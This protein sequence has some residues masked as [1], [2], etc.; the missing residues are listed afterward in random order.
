M[1]AASKKVTMDLSKNK[2]KTTF[3][4]LTLLFTN[5]IFGIVIMISQTLT[6]EI[7][8]EYYN[9]APAEV[10]IKCSGYDKGILSIL[11]EIPEIEEVKGT[12]TLVAQIVVNRKKVN[13]NLSV[14]DD[15]NRVNILKNKDGKSKIPSLQKNEI[16]I[17]RAAKGALGVLAGE[18]L[19]I[20]IENKVS[21]QLVLKDYVY[22]ASAEPY[23]LEG[24]VCGFITMDNYQSLPGDGKYHEI[25]L[26][27]KGDGTKAY[28]EAICN[29]ASDLLSKSGVTV[30][31]TEVVNSDSFYASLALKAINIILYVLGILIIIMSCSLIFNIFN[32]TMLQQ[33]KVIGI[34]K[35]YGGSTAQ[36]SR[37]Y[38]AQMVMI[39]L[40]TYLLSIPISY[41]IAKFVS[42]KLA[43]F[44]NI[45]L[46]KSGMPLFLP[47]VLFVSTLIIP[48]LAVSIPIRKAS[49]ATV[50]DAMNLNGKGGSFKHSGG[51]NRLISRLHTLSMIIRYAIRNQMKDRLRSIL[52][53]AALVLSCTILMTSLNL[54]TSLS[55]TVKSYRS[56]IPDIILT[57]DNLYDVNQLK[58]LISDTKEIKQVE[59]WAFTTALYVEKG[60]DNTKKVLMEGPPESSTLFDENTWARKLQSGRLLKHDNSNEIVINNHLLYY[61]PDIQLG[62][63]ITLQINQKDY[64]FKVVGI[65][66][67]F[68]QPE[69]PTVY[70]NY[71]YLNQ[72]L[73]VKDKVRDMRLQTISLSEK[74][75]TV[76]INQIDTALNSA[77]I[78]LREINTGAE[79][80]EEF[81][82]GIN[83]VIALLLVLSLF[84]L[85]VGTIGLAGSL[86]I[87]VMERTPEFGIMRAVGGSHKQINI[88]I[89]LEGLILTG[90]AWLIGNLLSLPI[91][92]ALS[93][94]L[95]YALFATP[96]SFVLNIPGIIIGCM[97][98]FAMTLLS[99]RIPSRNLN[100]LVTR[101]MLIY[102]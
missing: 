23:T 65:L 85:I 38:Y 46:Q 44:L 14:L 58:S 41:L 8:K 22:D 99:C 76:L 61:Y 88:F 39:G 60:G 3:I 45:S 50:Y 5:I 82:L 59:G 29:K 18:T 86:N 78:Q 21:T 101:D 10:I 68:G 20:I 92:Y 63:T 4:I 25:Y 70:V 6:P 51:M 72:I 95:G 36:I 49:R 19:D 96:A 66:S 12:T 42:N 34:M 48:L 17:E 2:L 81:S 15:N 83:L 57:M 102:E 27:V 40:F 52:T 24:D 54:Q 32:S 47:V 91:T 33:I 75:Q 67:V 74:E 31:E 43:Y 87:S 71:T 93:K 79:K 16:F 84:M 30:T 69:S 73:G 80:F 55:S 97:A 89:L 13:M 9:A 28:N 11:K 62:D 64:D 26:T 37:M 77:G 90:A 53:I 100:K 7:K 98:A 56:L 94:V 1:K 35:S